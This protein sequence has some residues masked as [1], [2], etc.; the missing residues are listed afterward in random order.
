MAAIDTLLA[1]LDDREI[2]QQIGL[3]HDEAR[4]RYPLHSN[5]VADFD[6]FSDVIADYYNY[7][8][9]ECVSRGGSLSRSESAGRAKEVAIEMLTK[10]G[11]RIESRGSMRKRCY[12][13]ILFGS[14]DAQQPVD[15]VVEFEQ[16]L[17][18]QG[19]QR[20]L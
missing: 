20:P 14:A 19:P 18:S 2:A 3:P 10:A 7:H 6:E 15:P 9:G 8:F 12:S 13:H 5:T 17:A 11:D 4:M 1:A 16:Q